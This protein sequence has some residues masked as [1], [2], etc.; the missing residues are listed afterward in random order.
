[1]RGSAERSSSSPRPHSI[2]TTASGR[3][4]HSD[5]S[6]RGWMTDE[7]DDLELE[8][9]E[10]ELE[11]AVRGRMR[12]RRRVEYGEVLEDEHF[13]EAKTASALGWMWCCICCSLGQSAVMLA[14]AGICLDA[15]IFVLVSAL[16]NHGDC[17][18]RW[19]W[20]VVEGICT[21]AIGLILGVSGYFGLCSGPICAGPGGLLAAT[22][23]IFKVVW[24]VY[25]A[26]FIF[27]RGGAGAGVMLRANSGLGGA[28][29]YGMQQ[30]HRHGGTQLR[31]TAFPPPP[32]AVDSAIA[33]LDEKCARVQSVSYYWLS[34][35][36]ILE[37][38]G[39]VLIVLALALQV[40]CVCCGADSA[41]SLVT[42]ILAHG[43]ERA[44]E[45][46]PLLP[47]PR[48][49]RRRSDRRGGGAVATAAAA[50][51]AGGGGGGRRRKKTTAVR[52]PLAGIRSVVPR[53]LLRLAAAA[54]E[55]VD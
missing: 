42:R 55:G 25:G 32:P 46:E 51:G 35:M 37:P 41:K 24:A 6:V 7:D 27:A 9:A 23:G 34:A 44:A 5:P 20:L 50:A 4:I 17:T 15:G 29:L 18:A 39:L 38:L 1:M 2:G 10:N 31:P 13:R 30:L 47:A 54:G 19:T 3:A 40:C 43:D 49:V 36:V 28:P 53:T 33:A 52:H 12:R 21:I 11:A 45:H 16:T 14:V 48:V 22:I 26:R 8:A